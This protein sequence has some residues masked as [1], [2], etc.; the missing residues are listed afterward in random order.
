MFVEALT[1]I[2]P[3]NLT[4]AKLRDWRYCSELFNLSSKIEEDI[5]KRYFFL[6]S[7]YSQ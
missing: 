1:Y 6:T 5:E 2:T 3:S 7:L 4:E